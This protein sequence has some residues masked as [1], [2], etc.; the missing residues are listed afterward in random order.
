MCFCSCDKLFKMETLQLNFG[1]SIH[2]RG[3]EVKGANKSRWSNTGDET[4]PSGET[5][6]VMRTKKSR[7]G[8]THGDAGLKARVQSVSR[9]FPFKSSS[10]WVS[11]PSSETGIMTVKTFIFIV[12]LLQHLQ[13]YKSG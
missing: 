7:E 12:K 1:S 8:A 2:K 6:Q 13:L 11:V 3:Q 4:Y 5:L 9:S 10:N